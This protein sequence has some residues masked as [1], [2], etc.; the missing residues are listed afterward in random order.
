MPR[1]FLAR[2]SPSSERARLTGAP[3]PLTRAAAH[4]LVNAC[5]GKNSDGLALARKR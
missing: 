3:G 5:R 1:C 2:R 4:K